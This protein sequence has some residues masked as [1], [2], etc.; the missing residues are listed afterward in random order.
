MTVIA[1]GSG[2]RHRALVIGSGLGGATA[3]YPA[4]QRQL[5]DSLQDGTTKTAIEYIAHCSTS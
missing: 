3:I 4:G 1:A 2:Q 5:R